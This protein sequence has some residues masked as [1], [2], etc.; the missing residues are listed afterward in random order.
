MTTNDE[1]VERWLERAAEAGRD[2]R[3][4]TERLDEAIRAGL[5]RAGEARRPLRRLRVAA[6]RSGAAAAIALIILAVSIRVFPGFAAAVS[7]LPGMDAIVRLIAYDRGLQAAVRNDYYQPLGATR[8][9]DGVT[10][11][12]DG[13]I[14][15]EGRLVLFYT[16]TDPEAAY[17]EIDSPRIRLQDG[18][19][20]AAAYSWGY[21]AP[22]AAER[23]R[24][25][26]NHIEIQFGDDIELP[27]AFTLEAELLR[28]GTPVG[29]TWELPIELASYDPAEL[30]TEYP[31]DR[32]VV[33]EG[34]R[35]TF[36]RA[37]VYPTRIA[38]EA[39]FDE[40]NTKE[41]FS[42]MDLKLIGDDGE[43][44]REQGGI[45]SH[46]RTRLYYFQG[47]SFDMPESLTLTGTTARALDK[48]RLDFVVDTESGVVLRKPDDRLS[49]AVSRPAGK[50][51]EIRMKVTGIDPDDR[52]IYSYVDGRFTDASGRP[53][54]TLGGQYSTDNGEP[55][56][57]T[58]MFEIPDAEY[59]QPLTFRIFN[60]PT[61][62]REPFEIR[63]R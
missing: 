34:Q 7:Q 3:V 56:S 22:D 27:R 51:I 14:E 24:T 1:R 15:D 23:E 25:R 53:F 26:T 55:E 48:D 41:I 37:V 43:E 30:R 45:A 42:F 40:A 57:Q 62:V 52:T 38:V 39:E 18:S 31:I 29:G 28:E 10:L 5:R 13:V 2:V 35:V 47:S 60:Y 46:G 50:P 8:T 36:K 61:Y 19:G 17:V 49:V 33:M 9:E 4:P 6:L 20:L 21:A 63:I 16:V 32:V 59:E 44:Y 54:D 12:V 58:G 11:T